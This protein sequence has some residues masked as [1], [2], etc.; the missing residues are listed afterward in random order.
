MPTSVSSTLTRAQAGQTPRSSQ[1]LPHH[2]RRRPA[3][4]RVAGADEAVG[5]IALRGGDRQDL[6]HDVARVAGGGADLQA[7]ARSCATVCRTRDEVGVAAPRPPR[8]SARRRRRPRRCRPRSERARA[9]L[10]Q[11]AAMRG[12]AISAAMCGRLAMP[13]GPRASSMVIV[14]AELARRP[15]RRRP[16]ARSEPWSTHGAGPVEDHGLDGAAWMV[17]AVSASDV[18]NRSANDSS[19]MAKAVLA[20]VPLVTDHEPHVRRAARR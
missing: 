14:D 10:C 11:A 19:A 6:G 8:S 13:I 3:V 7:A 5:R 16:S 2:E 18:S 4:R 20:P 9:S 15:R 12:S 17:M 1:R